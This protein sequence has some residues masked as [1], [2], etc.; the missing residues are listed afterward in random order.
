MQR[1]HASISFPV[2]EGTTP[3]AA[4][5]RLGQLEAELRVTMHRDTEVSGG[6]LTEV[7]EPR[8]T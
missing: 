5:E 2:P 6:V 7:I 1:L 3:E 4:A 8:R